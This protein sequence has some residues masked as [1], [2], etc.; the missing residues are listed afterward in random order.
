MN[1]ANFS[2]GG[3]IPSSGPESALTPILLRS[4]EM[5]GVPHL[6]RAWLASGVS[7]EEWLRRREEGGQR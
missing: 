1:D 2:P 7:L 6:V 5:I 3:I 4:G